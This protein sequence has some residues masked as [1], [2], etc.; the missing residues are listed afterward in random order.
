MKKVSLLLFFILPI[1]CVAVAQRPFIITGKL[2]PLKEGK[3]FLQYHQDDRAI[4]DSTVLKNGEFQLKGKI[5]G[6]QKAWLQVHHSDGTGYGQDF[7]LEP[8][9]VSVTANNTSGGMT[10]KSGKT[11][12]DFLMLRTQE[13]QLYHKIAEIQVQYQEEKD[14]AMR[15]VIWSR[16]DTIWNEVWEMEKTYIL[17]HPDSY[18]SFD[19]IKTKSGP[20]NSY[21]Y[22]SLFD[23]LSDRLRSSKESKAFK[24]LATIQ[25]RTAIGNQAPDFTQ[26]TSEGLPVTLASLDGKY[27]LLDFWASWCKPCREDN[28]NLLKVYNQFRHKNFEVLAVSLDNDRERWEKAIKQDG[29]PWIQVSD[30]QG[31]KNAVAEA[32]G[33]TGIPQNFLIDPKGKIIA[34]NLHDKDLE[35]ALEKYL[36]GYQMSK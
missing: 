31:R 13:K 28:P 8:G 27:V 16:F 30:L 24:A 7:F 20:I 18:L 33:I 5:S 17:A 9:S 23:G 2:N 4:S 36:E 11:Q 3:V 32:Y 26:N 19:L 35:E 6:I 34:R 10:I 12:N 22:E 21:K 15:K 25:K 1:C 29:L 14:K